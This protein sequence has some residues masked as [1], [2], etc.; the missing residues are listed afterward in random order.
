VHPPHRWRSVRSGFG[1][2]LQGLQIARQILVEIRDRQPVHAHGT[3]AAGT[4]IRSGQ[5]ALVDVVGQGS[6]SHVRSLFRQLGY[7]LLFR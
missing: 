4:L 3:I 5:P 1:A 2:V 6:E 7:P